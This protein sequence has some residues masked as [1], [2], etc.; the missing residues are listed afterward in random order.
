MNLV[1]RLREVQRLN[2]FLKIYFKN[3]LPLKVILKDWCW[4][5]G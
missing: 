2:L 4:S 3:N 1:K 5:A